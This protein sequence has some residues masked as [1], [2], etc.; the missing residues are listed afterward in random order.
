MTDFRSLPGRHNFYFLRHGE[1][2]GNDAGILQGRQDYAL[3]ARGMEQARQAAQWFADKGIERMLSSPL[4]RGRQTAE[5]LAAALGVQTIEEHD[6]LNELDIGVFT[7]LTV[8]QVRR[9]YPA[10][11]RRFQ[12]RSWQAVPRAERI[13][14][15]VRRAESLW[16]RLEELGHAGCQ[17]VLCVT[18][19]GILQWLV[20][21]TFG[22]R[23]WM[24]LVPM[25]NCAISLFTVDNRPLPEAAGATPPGATPPGATASGATPP[26]ATVSGATVSVAAGS[27]A[28]YYCEWSL[29]NHRPAL[30]ESPAGG[31]VVGHVFLRP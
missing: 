14:S 8:E 17:N 9:Q 16:R 24:P 25:N 26:G 11:W 10:A 27:T 22:Q 12:R 28:R 30:A 18:H 15:L 4:L 29:L 19:S 31:P 7:G 23:R 3:S 13:A 5:L 21:V 2:L 1:S 20:K 6:G